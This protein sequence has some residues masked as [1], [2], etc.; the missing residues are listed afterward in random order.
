LARYKV[1]LSQRQDLIISDDFSPRKLISLIIV[2]DS[3][4][5]ANPLLISTQISQFLGLI[6]LGVRHNSL[7][8]I[9]RLQILMRQG[10]LPNLPDLPP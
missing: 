8:S 10:F 1:S 5:A 2:E 3:F 6:E 4:E 7:V 9:R